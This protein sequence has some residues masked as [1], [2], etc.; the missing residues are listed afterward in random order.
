M[1]NDF[2]FTTFFILT[3]QQ[4]WTTF[5]GKKVDDAAKVGYYMMCAQK[6]NKCETVWLNSNVLPSPWFVA[7]VN[8]INSI[9]KGSI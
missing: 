2:C 9:I 8:Q 3:N 4:G 7:L 6:K 1:M 5:R